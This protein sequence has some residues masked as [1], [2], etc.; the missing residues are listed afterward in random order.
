MKDLNELTVPALRR[1]LGRWA[2]VCGGLALISLSPLG[3][4]KEPAVPIVIAHR[5]ASGHRPEHTLEAYELAIQMGADYIEPDLV[6]TKDGVLIV[7]HENELSDTTDVAT[8]FPTRKTTKVID[9]ETKEGYFAED[10]TLSEIKELRARERLKFRSHD[11]DGQ[12]TVP[13]FAEVLALVARKRADRSRPI[14]VYPELKHPAYF[15]GLGFK[16]EETL[17][18]ELQKAGYSQRTDPV[19][20]QS[21]EPTCL[22]TLRRM[23]ELRL[24]QLLD[25][26]SHR[27]YDLVKA[28]DPRTFGDLSKPAGLDDI[29][30]Y[31]DGIGVNK[32]LI[33]PL[34][35][36]GRTLPPTT[37]IT[38]AHARKLKVHVFTFRQEV[39]FIPPDFDF[40]VV[41]EVRAYLK[42]GVDGLFCDFPDL[43]LQARD[44]NQG[45][46][47]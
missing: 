35:P 11:Y 15:A 10:F 25:D 14:G 3:C 22:R 27:P 46:A 32:E 41:T 40:D 9:G 39:V 38:D 19:F 1:S 13:T 24:V 33:L 31:A 21:F 5:G 42:L 23:T 47:K 7:R 28:G 2:R 43:C 36:G 8:R 17:L 4:V 12:F 26:A 37:I 30:S 6:P 18:S 45:T 16:Q 34:A 44:E 29:A 20:I